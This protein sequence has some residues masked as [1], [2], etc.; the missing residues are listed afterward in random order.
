MAELM[1]GL[2]A[3]LWSGPLLWILLG[4]H[5]YYT[6]KLRGVGRHVF[7]GIRLSLRRGQGEDGVSPFGALTTSLAAAIGTGNIIGVATAIAL[8]GPGAV[9]WCWISGVLGMATRYGETWICLRHRRKL[10]EKGFAGGP[11]YV[12]E[13]R[14][15]WPGLGKCFAFLGVAAAFSTGAMIQ[16]NAAAV[17]VETFCGIPAAVTGAVLTA[18]AGLILMFGLRGIARVSEMLV[19]AMSGLYLLGCV[20]VLVLCR[21]DIPTAISAILRGAFSGTGAIG[22]ISGYSVG[23]ALRYGMARGLFTNEAG[24]GTAPMAAA[25]GPGKNP[26]EEALISMTGVFWDT[27]VICAVTG[28][29]LVTG[30]LSYPGVLMENPGGGMCYGV[31]SLLPGGG[32]I[33]TVCLVVFAFATVIGWS[34]YGE[35]CWRYLFGKHTGQLYRVLYLTAVFVGALTKLE[36][37][38]SLGSILAGLMAVPNLTG[39]FLCREEL[40]QSILPKRMAEKQSLSGEKR[41]Y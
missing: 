32:G 29:T 21:R 17:T 36:T 3:A 39:M 23:A 33:L 24:M 38:W 18:A 30:I 16:S 9:F 31:F 28:I 11:M 8:G 19:P 2:E 15:S 7:R 27:V 13:D 12:M 4:S 40:A 35:C 26:E 34:W 10:P 5:V 1:G 14:L 20:G 41:T 6:L 37:L 25:A 22:G